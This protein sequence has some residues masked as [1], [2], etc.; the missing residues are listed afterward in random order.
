MKKYLIV[1]LIASLFSFD[2]E[3]NT[4]DD[5]IINAQIEKPA[6]VLDYR[7]NKKFPFFKKKSRHKRKHKYKNT[8]SSGE[9]PIKKR[10]FDRNK[11]EK[12]Q[13]SIYY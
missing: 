13:Q 5:G 6:K 1:I 4:G 7:Y 12:R 2:D 10:K 11:S 8:E 3:Y 9:K